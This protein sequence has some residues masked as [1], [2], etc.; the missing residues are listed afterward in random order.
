MKCFD[1]KVCHKLWIQMLS[2]TKSV[3]FCFH[4]FL[5]GTLGISWGF[6][7]ETKF[8][9]PLLNV[10][11]QLLKKIFN[12]SSWYESYLVLL[13]GC[14]LSFC[15]QSNTNKLILVIF[16][17]GREYKN[18]LFP[19]FCPSGQW[20]QFPSIAGIDHQIFTLQLTPT[21]V[22]WKLIFLSL[23]CLAMLPLWICLAA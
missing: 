3:K 2:A 10:F 19:Q 22:K 7:T 5:N 16:H 20:E 21:R 15:S 11:S 18:Q 9:S 12:C 17:L 4:F 23:H 14:C 13:L 1:Q 6:F 8:L